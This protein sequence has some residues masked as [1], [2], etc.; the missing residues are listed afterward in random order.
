MCLIKCPEKK[1]TERLK[2]LL[3]KNFYSEFFKDEEFLGNSICDACKTRLYSTEKPS[4]RQNRFDDCVIK[5][6]KNL[7]KFQL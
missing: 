4:P 1:L 2:N 6:A 7:I 3:Q 5:F